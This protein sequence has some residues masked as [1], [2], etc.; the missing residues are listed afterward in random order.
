MLFSS[1][2]FI[3]IF[4]PVTLLVVGVL[5]R[6]GAPRAA[7]SALVLASL[8][9]YGYWEPKYLLLLTGSIAVNYQLGI[10]IATGA[11][12]SGKG[13]ARPRRGTQPTRPRLLQIRGFCGRERHGPLRP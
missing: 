7:L 12:G 4:L 8:F 5:G 2:E 6:V 13:V 3:L 11:R 1:L 9:F 10:A